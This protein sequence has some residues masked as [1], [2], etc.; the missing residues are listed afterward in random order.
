MKPHTTST[1]VLFHFMIAVTL[2][3]GSVPA[4]SADPGWKT[5]EENSF[6]FMYPSDW[7]YL[8]MGDD[9]FNGT[10]AYIKALRPLDQKHFAVLI[11]LFPEFTIDLQAGKLTFADFIK[12]VFTGALESTEEDQTKI[13]KTQAILKHGQVPAFML[14]SEQSKEAFKATLIC[15]DL[16]KGAAAIIMIRLELTGEEMEMSKTYLDQAEAIMASFAFPH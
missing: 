16:I 11:F 15:G 4:L 8:D 14:I 2:L 7:V 13:E 10:T 5:V 9:D 1:R 6:S 3:L 12:M